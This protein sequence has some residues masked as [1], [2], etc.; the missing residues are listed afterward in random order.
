MF[1]SGGIVC[2][3]RGGLTILMWGED[4]DQ[5]V[6]CGWFPVDEAR[7]VSFQRDPLEK[8]NQ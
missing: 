4:I 6:A 3:R 8:V 7:C 1:N 5:N 2:L